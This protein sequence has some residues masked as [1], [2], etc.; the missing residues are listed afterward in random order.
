MHH[1]V[2]FVIRLQGVNHLDGFLDEF[3]FFVGQHATT[4]SSSE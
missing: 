3:I 1:G 4:A 2:E